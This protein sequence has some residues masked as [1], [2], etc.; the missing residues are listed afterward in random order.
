VSP[1]ASSAVVVGV[2]HQKTGGLV[3]VLAAVPLL[4]LALLLVVLIR[5]GPADMIRGTNVPPVEK[6]AITQVQLLPSS[7]ELS[8][9]NDGP[10]VVT[11]AQVVV[12]DAFWTFSANP[13]PTLSHLQRTRVSIPYPWVQGETHVVRLL[14]STGLTFERTIPVAVETPTPNAR[15]LGIFALV[16]LYVGVIPVALG[17]LWYPLMSRIGRAGLQFLLALTVGL[18]VYLL[19]D[20]AFDGLEAARLVPG[21][22]QGPALFVFGAMAAYLTLDV[23]GKWLSERRQRTRSTSEL[24]AGWVLAVLIAVGIGLHNFG[25]GLA[26]GSAFALGELGLGTLLIVG[27]TLHNTTEGLAIVAPLARR[28]AVERVGIGRLIQL[29]LIGGVPTILGAWLG[30]FVYSSLLAVFFL[31]LG[32]GA[33]AQVTRQIVMQG[34]RDRGVAAYFREGPV[35]AGLAAGVAIMYVTGLI[36][37]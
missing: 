14:T 1:E 7:I 35:V 10:D 16:G 9:F 12:D 28:P 21:S 22:L 8:V 26:I 27:F 11:I 20:A 37:G 18:L 3:W 2:V 29:G 4:L 34:A 15:F 25:E 31:A 24:P 30:A 33:I 6:L 19:I 13:G 36:I 5:S 23:I 32:V 17:L